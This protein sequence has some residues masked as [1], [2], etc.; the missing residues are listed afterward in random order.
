MTTPVECRYYGRDFTTAEMALLR[1]LIAGP[2]ALNRHAL[3][4]EFCRRIGWYKADGG[5]KDMMARV[6]MLACTGTAVSNCRR[7]SGARTRQRRSPS[8]SRPNRP[9]AAADHARRRPPGPADEAAHPRP[10]PPPAARGLDRALQDDP[11]AHRDLRGKP[12]ATPAPS[13]GS[14]AGSASVPLRGA[15]ATART[16]ATTS[17][18]GTSG[19]GPS[20]RTGSAP[21][22][23][24]INPAPARPNAYV[25]SELPKARR[26]PVGKWESTREDLSDN[27]SQVIL[28]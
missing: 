18:G 16:G 23:G 11:R 26:F 9:P 2:P 14:P 24:R 20:A 25:H 28:Y 12:P 3:S 21:S 6:V 15:D 19:C 13:A 1:T 22:T 7:R 8:G 17:P 10:R 4:K 27:V 5:I